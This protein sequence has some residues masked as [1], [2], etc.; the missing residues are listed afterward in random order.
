VA[1][2]V[3]LCVFAAP[4]IILGAVI[5]AGVVVVA[6]AIK[7][8]WDTYERKASLE[9]AGPNPKHQSG[10][11]KNPEPFLP[12][13][14]TPE[15]L[16]EWRERCAEHYVRCSDYFAGRKEPRVYGESLCQSCSRIC[17]RTGHW[18]AEFN[19]HPCPGG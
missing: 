18:P 9:R 16:E 13:N 3:G 14:P 7:E 4:E 15:E 8:E 17:R 6:T 19:G 11:K 1:V 5:I 10:P 2:G 12:P